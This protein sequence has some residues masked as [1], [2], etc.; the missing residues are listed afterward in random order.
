MAEQRNPRLAAFADTVAA[1]ARAGATEAL[2]V[3]RLAGRIAPIVA[4]IVLA[5]LRERDEEREIGVAE[6][7]KL[8]GCHPDTVRRN[9]AEWGGFK[10]G[11]GERAHWRFRVSGCHPIATSAQIPRQE[12]DS[13]AND[14]PGVRQSE[15]E[16]EG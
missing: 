6:M 8:R 16:D 15:G 13:E 2:D 4:E 9:A 11:R 12:R 14:G 3:D 10:P 1:A 5:A 7:A